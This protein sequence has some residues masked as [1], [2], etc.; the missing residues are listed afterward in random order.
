MTM[1][2]LT[3][4]LFP[5]HVVLF[6]GGSLPL[7]IFEPRYLDMISH[8]MRNE[9]D[10]GICLI[11][12]GSEVGNAAKPYPVGTLASVR[13]FQQLRD[14]CLGITAQGGQR[15]RIDTTTVQP[16]QL[17]TAEI[18]LI[19]AEPSTTLPLEFAGLASHLAT[20]IERLGQ[21]YIAMEVNYDDA[22]WV[23]SRLAELLPLPLMQKQYFL[24]LNDPIERLQR[25]SQ[26]IE[27]FDFS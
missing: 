22:G 16:N 13:Y 26:L 5:L 17:L 9:T 27:E 8:C 11:E 25:I 10:F 12:E 14:G 23:G 24:Q 1:A 20:L 18:E 2:K 15:F 19:D 21:P 3:I 6:P 7:R 4:P